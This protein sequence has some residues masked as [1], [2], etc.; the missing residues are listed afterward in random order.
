MQI[1]QIQLQL[2]RV[3]GINQVIKGYNSNK[4]LVSINTIELNINNLIKYF[5]E[6]QKIF[7]QTSASV[8]NYKYF[9]K[10]QLNLSLNFCKL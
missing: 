4:F 5:T 3:G 9:K 10:E 8:A 6:S 1:K 7:K 2:S